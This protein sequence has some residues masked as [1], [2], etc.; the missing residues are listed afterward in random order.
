MM[1]LSIFSLSFCLVLL[2]RGNILVL[3]SKV[4]SP[5]E[6]RSYSFDTFLSDY[7]K[8]YD[9]SQQ[10]YDRRYGIFHHNKYTIL[11][12]NFLNQQNSN[13]TLGINQ[14]LDMLENELPLGY[15]KSLH[16]AY[17]PEKSEASQLLQLKLNKYRVRGLGE[18]H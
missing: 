1:M 10:E 2:S 9:D 5:E 8:S 4:R 15:D 3:A 14:F 7:G 18:A 17:A 13:Y 16:R 6:L 12:H 11:K